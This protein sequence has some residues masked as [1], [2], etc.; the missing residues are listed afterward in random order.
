MSARLRRICAGVFAGG[1]DADAA[2]NAAAFLRDIPLRYDAIALFNA[3]HDERAQLQAEM[4]L[5]VL[6][7]QAD[8][9]K[10]NSG[11]R[12]QNNELLPASFLAPRQ[13]KVL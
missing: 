9:E 6:K 3:P 4:R 2:A 12:P 11:G 13:F 10:E 5:A 1:E 8:N 7:G